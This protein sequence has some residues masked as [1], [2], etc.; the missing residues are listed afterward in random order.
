MHS[1]SIP[2]ALCVLAGGKLE[3]NGAE[4]IFR[5]EATAGSETFGIV[6][7]PFMLQKARTTAFKMTLRISGDELHY[8]ETTSLDIYGRQFEHTDGCTLARVIYD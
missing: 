5:V 1:L 8:E 3:Q 2:R 4:T 6:Q 7:S